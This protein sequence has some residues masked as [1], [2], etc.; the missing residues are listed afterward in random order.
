MRK[1][2][3]K[4]LTLALVVVATLAISGVARAV[5]EEITW[6]HVHGA[7]NLPCGSDVHW[8]LEK[9][10]GIVAVELFV[11]GVSQGLM[12]LQGMHFTIISDAPV[13]DTTAVTAVVTEGIQENE[14]A[15]LTLSSCT[16]PATTPPPGEEPPPPAVTGFNPL[17]FVGLGLLLLA[18]GAFALRR[19]T[20]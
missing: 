10:D 19:R 11:D 18:G 20:V 17:P 5:D 1:V 15:F 13:D 7:T 12:E 16:P 8:N 3:A 2:T 14:D 9:A 4:V 6:D